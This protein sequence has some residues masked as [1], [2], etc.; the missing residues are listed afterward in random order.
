MKYSHLFFNNNF[1]E[2]DNQKFE[3]IDLMRKAC[4]VHAD[5]SGIYSWLSL[6][7]ILEQKVE[8]I[9][10]EEMDN[11]CFSQIRLSILQDADL[12]KATGRFDTYGAELFKLQNRKNHDFCLG[13]TCEEAITQ[14]VKNHY[15]NS[16]MNVNVYQMGNK[17]RDELRAKGGL[18]R[19]KE[20]I[21]KDGYSFASTEEQLE[22]TYALVRQAYC[23]IFNRL[24]LEY[25]IKSSDNGEIGGKS[26]E[27]FHCFSNY[28]EDETDGK[29]SLEV[30]HIF[31]LGQE[32]SKK[33]NLL[34]NT[35][36]HVYMGCY[37]I[38]ISRMVMALL[39]KQRD[40]F[41][42]F[43]TE[44]FNTYHTVI[45]V[46][47][48]KVEEHRQ[49]ALEIYNIL[50]S[51]GISVLLDDRETNAGKKMSDSELIG[52]VKRIVVSKQSFKNQAFEIL[53][54]QT[55][56]KQFIAFSDISTALQNWK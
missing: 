50:K 27:E 2:R 30:A 41:G 47:D 11:I 43:G 10:Q 33:M 19:S 21:M 22:E 39:E 14:I 9:I 56:E 35:K 1:F 31:N 13:A 3:L 18:M 36:E 37:G 16:Q 53:N 17:Y 54:R 28:G 20:F 40:Q 44:S 49:K 6:G 23:N 38:G 52:C 51:K 12:W 45:S 42:F 24:G 7:L 48:Y 55:M 4:F 25:V 5:S 34:N 32:Y 8:K 15:N 26:S 46:I 29:T